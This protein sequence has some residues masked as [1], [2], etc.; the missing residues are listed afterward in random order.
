VIGIRKFGKVNGVLRGAIE[1]L[2]R[3]EGGEGRVTVCAAERRAEARRDHSC[4]GE[5]QRTQRRTCELVTNMH[6]VT[7]S[8]GKAFLGFSGYMA[9]IGRSA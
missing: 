6:I 3:D 2:W 9:D 7:V 5:R 8:Y 4:L 1:V